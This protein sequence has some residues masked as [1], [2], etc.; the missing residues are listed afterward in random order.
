[1]AE[2]CVCGD[3]PYEFHKMWRVRTSAFPVAEPVNYCN[4]RHDH[5]IIF[6]SLNTSVKGRRSSVVYFF[7]PFVGA[8]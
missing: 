5:G 8:R 7:V 3:E 1:M 2:H 6:A 4:G